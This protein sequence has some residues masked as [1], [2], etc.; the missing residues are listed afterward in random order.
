M[1]NMNE[2]II[3]SVIVPIY[4]VEKYLEKCINSIL[5]QT[6]KK[7]EL[8]LVDDGSTDKCGKICDDYSKKYSQI[9]V[10]HKK[11][12][13]LSDAR[14]AGIVIALGDYITFVD[15]DDYLDNE[16]LQNMY[17]MAIKF[18]ADLV[19]C[20]SQNV[21]ENKK[22]TLIKNDNIVSEVIT[23]EQAYKKILL[24]EG[25]DVSACRKLY[26]TKIFKDNKILYPVGEIYED[27][28]VIDKVV[29]SC[30]KIVITNYI[31]YYYLQRNGSIM[32][33][34]MSQ[35]NFIL[36]EAITK[37]TSFIKENY[38]NISYAAN[39]RYVYCNFHILGRAIFDKNYEEECNKIRDNIL[40]Y[41]DEIFKSN[42]YSL[43][44][45]IATRT[46]KMGLKPYKC[47][48]KIY[49]ILKGKKFK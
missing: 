42:L 43:K 24:Q 5:D 15:S 17:E 6:F 7:Y 32:Y 47:F 2:D 11:N 22:N 10:I 31:G 30:S 9:K 16:Y 3:I 41:S 29:E 21:Y 8:I 39:K 4:N 25:T 18:S 36:I 13:G 1:I 49:C 46:L 35:K 12:G 28:Q 48:W 20:D 37:L 38:P 27:I 14:N 33:G 23:K 34:K 26:K 19:M 40:K 44:E 45:K